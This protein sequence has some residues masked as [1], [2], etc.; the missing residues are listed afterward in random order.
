MYMYLVFKSDSIVSNA[1]RRLKYKY[2]ANILFPKH[3]GRGETDIVG[4]DFNLANFVDLISFSIIC[5]KT[6][7]QLG[8]VLL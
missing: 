6:E 8:A 4:F 5:I 1:R 7:L 2:V 3:K